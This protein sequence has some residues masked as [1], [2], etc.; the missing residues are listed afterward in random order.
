MKIYFEQSGGIAGINDSISIDSDLL[1]PEEQLELER[2]IG[3]ANFF[4]I[5]TELGKDPLRGAD[6][7]SYKISVEKD[8]KRHSIATT[9]LTMP[10]K[11]SPLLRY[12]KQKVLRRCTFSKRG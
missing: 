11:L 4:N 8:L 10:P 9:D 7:F 12:L 3:I 1:Q 5:P 6:F 2:L